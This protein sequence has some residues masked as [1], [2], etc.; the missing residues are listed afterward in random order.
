MQAIDDPQGRVTVFELFERP[1]MWNS[2]WAREPFQLF[3]PTVFGRPRGAGE[4]K[5]IKNQASV[6]EESLV[7][8]DGSNSL[9]DHI[10]NLFGRSTNRQTGDEFVEMFNDPAIIRVRYKQASDSRSPA[11]YQD[12]RQIYIT[13]RRM[14]QADHGPCTLVRAAPDKDE[15]R[16][17]Y[18]LMAIVLCS[19]QAGEA[20]RIR[21]Y[22]VVGHPLSLP[23]RLNKYV[24][25]YW[26][27]GDVD[28]AGRIYLLFYGRAPP[29]PI[30]GQHEEPIAR[31]E[32]N[33]K[34]LIKA[35]KASTISMSTK[36]GDS[37]S[38]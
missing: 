1:A 3:H 7:D 24:G 36:A 5:V 2:L 27:M 15:E 21:L 11:T 10:S 8:W 16:V 38:V 20:D 26:N 32:P 19:G 23:I 30:S 13:P 14:K 33:A 37:S 35:M 6:V 12:L 28:D 34:S 31:K 18:T 22:S 29:D 25:T 17:P 4:W 9:G